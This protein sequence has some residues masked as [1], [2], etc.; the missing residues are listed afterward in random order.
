MSAPAIPDFPDWVP[1][2]S[3]VSADRV[4]IQTPAGGGPIPYDSG[5]IDAGPWQSAVIQAWGAASGTVGVARLQVTHYVAGIAMSTDSAIFNP[6]SSAPAVDSGIIMQLPLLGDQFRVQIQQY[7]D[8]FQAEIL[9][10]VSTR[11]VV[12]HVQPYQSNAL[13]PITL[14]GSV[15]VP[16]TSTVSLGLV[17]PY[18]NG[19]HIGVGYSAVGVYI[20][21]NVYGWA[22]GGFLSHPAG[23]VLS[24]ASAFAYG[25]IVA[26]NT[27]AEV[28]VGNTLTGSHNV[29]YVA[30]GH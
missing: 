30:Q 12:K 17:G 28:E 27:V 25:D 6:L 4:V 11:P 9:A 23:S 3:V 7:S 19:W 10:T 2:Q 29:A 16:A 26:P 1:G 22:G 5:L 14:I 21:A 18:D 8:V 24:E 20:T 13:P 15:L